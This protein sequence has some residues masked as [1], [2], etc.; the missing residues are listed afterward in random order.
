MLNT[1]SPDPTWEEL[2]NVND[3]EL[4]EAINELRKC[5]RNDLPVSLDVYTTLEDWGIEIDKLIQ[6]LEKDL[7]GEDDVYDSY[8]GC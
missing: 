7:D 8:W 1:L 3:Y 2:V 4:D 6:E 5:V